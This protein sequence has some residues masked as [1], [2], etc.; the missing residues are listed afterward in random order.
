MATFRNDSLGVI[1][2]WNRSTLNPMFVQFQVDVERNV[3][4][5]SNRKRPRRNAEI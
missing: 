3:R 2:Q 4:Y 5:S 1:E